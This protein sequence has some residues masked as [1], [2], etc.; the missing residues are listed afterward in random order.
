MLTLADAM[1]A[2]PSSKDR[3]AAILGAAARL[4]EHY[5]HGKTTIADVAREAHVGVGTVY[6]EFDSKDAI[7]QALSSS[8]HGAVLDAMRAAATPPRAPAA[9]LTAVLVART[10]SFVALRNRGEHACELLFCRADA[11]RIAHERFESDERTLL[12]AILEDGT[13]KG[14]FAERDPVATAQLVQRAFAS[15][16]PPWIFEAPE[17]AVRTA[18]GLCRVLLHGLSRPARANGTRASSPERGSSKP[19]KP[20]PRPR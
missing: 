1:P 15:L 19:S 18:Q 5:G 4:F 12:V 13:R 7:V 8:S 17:D 2:P 6:L 3:R 10:R 9:R 11:V 14:A 16:S 20:K